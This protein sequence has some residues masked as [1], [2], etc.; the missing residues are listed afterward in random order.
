MKNEW[1]YVE[2]ELPP[3]GAEVLVVAE[4]DGGFT[5]HLIKFLD[6]REKRTGWGRTIECWHR[7]LSCG[8]RLAWFLPPEFKKREESE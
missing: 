5:T 4:I 7:D 8:K 6:S 2:D 3:I 1:I